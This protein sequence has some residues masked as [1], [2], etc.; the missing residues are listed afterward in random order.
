MA[1]IPEAEKKCKRESTSV[2]DGR[3]DRQTDKQTDR[4]TR[5]PMTAEAALAQPRA[6]KT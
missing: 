3:T 4:Q 1:G 6:A 5:H 2:T